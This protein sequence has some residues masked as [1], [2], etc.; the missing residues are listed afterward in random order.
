MDNLNLEKKNINETGWK[1]ETVKFSESVK[2]FIS[3]NYGGTE[4]H[5]LDLYNSTELHLSG[6]NT[7]VL[8]QATKGEI[9]P[10]KIEVYYENGKPSQIR[11]MYD[12]QNKVHNIDFYIN[13]RA[14]ED[15]LIK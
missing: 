3:S 9:E 15:F 8:L 6:D 1:D 10:T 2:D 12:G 4:K 14:L 11:V 13:G 7:E 5:G